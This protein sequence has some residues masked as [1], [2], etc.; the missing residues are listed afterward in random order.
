MS[1]QLEQVDEDRELRRRQSLV[2]AMEYGLVGAL[3]SQGIELLGLAL[4]WDAFSCLMTL[5]A[6]VGG[7]RSVSFVGA[8]TLID[9]FLKAAAQARSGALRWRAD[10]YHKQSA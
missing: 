2:K 7:V 1:R 5:R 10:K 6:D 9:S 3:E 4:K 8:E